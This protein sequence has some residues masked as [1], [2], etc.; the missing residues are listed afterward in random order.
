MVIEAALSDLS[1]ATQIHAISQAAYA[2]EAE[3]ISCPHFPPLRQSLD[4]LC[5]SSDRFLVFQQAEC[6]VGVLAYGPDTDP[7]MITRLVV[8][9]SNLRQG[10]ATALLFYLEQ[11]LPPTTRL[12]VSTAQAN[13]PA[14][15]LY[16]RLGYVHTTTT[17]SEEGLSLVHLAKSI[18]VQQLS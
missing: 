5:R 12:R 7:V 15:L 13:T 16:Q 2:L 4:D 3:L 10:I 9:P 1:I 14:I 11:T 17:T 18:R 8:N 6:V